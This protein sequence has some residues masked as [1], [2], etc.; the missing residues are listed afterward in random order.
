MSRRRA[1]IWVPKKSA[2]QLRAEV[3]GFPVLG[4]QA[5][6]R[7]NRRRGTRGC[8]TYPADEGHDRGRPGPPER[9]MVARGAR[10]Q[11]PTTRAAPPADGQGDDDRGG[12]QTRA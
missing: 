7:V 2:L 1:R 9:V 8:D 4:W 5:P 11:A 12:T 6:T 10:R 3:G